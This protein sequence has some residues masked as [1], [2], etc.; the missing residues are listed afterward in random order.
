M[1]DFFPHAVPIRTVEMIPAG[2][3]FSATR[4]HS[5]LGSRAVC[6]TARGNREEAAPKCGANPGQDLAEDVVLRG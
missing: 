6:V 1:L 2:V 4:K 3:T 5:H